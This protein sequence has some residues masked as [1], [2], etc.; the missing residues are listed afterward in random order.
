MVY[1]SEGKRCF[2]VQT[3]LA[4]EVRIEDVVFYVSVGQLSQYDKLHSEKRVSNVMCVMY[5]RI[6][7]KLCIRLFKV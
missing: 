1:V 6:A 3:F 4:E 5:C 7:I 2:S